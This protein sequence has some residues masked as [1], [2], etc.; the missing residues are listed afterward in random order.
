MAKRDFVAGAKGGKDVTDMIKTAVLVSGGGMTLQAILDSY[1]FQE[2]ENCELTAVISSD[3]DAYALTRA[4]AAMVPGYVVDA[5]LFPNINS[6]SNAVFGKLR[7]LD[8]DLVVL[9]GWDYGLDK[10]TLHYFRNRI[11]TTWPS[12]VPAF[13]DSPDQG[14]S[15]QERVIA[16]GVRITGGTSCFLTEDGGIGPII[17]QKAVE[18]RRGETAKSLQ[19]RV[20]EEAERTLLTDALQLYCAG[21]LT[22]ANG[23]V[24]ILPKE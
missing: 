20:M 11:I 23:L 5:S 8:I 16:A 21:R 10:Q 3:G 4:R 2:I 7:D 15:L 18:V 19:R 17:Q 1:F 6:F 13:C 22:V 24:D 14:L 9:A 12:L